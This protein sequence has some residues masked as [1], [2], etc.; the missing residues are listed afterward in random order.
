MGNCTCWVRLA[1]VTLLHR[2]QCRPPTN[3]L[4]RCVE[5]HA[6]SKSFV[7]RTSMCGGKGQ[8]WKSVTRLDI[9]FPG[10][11]SYV[12]SFFLLASVEQSPTPRGAKGPRHQ[13]YTN[14]IRLFQGRLV[15]G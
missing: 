10:G 9:C 12:A 2:Q 15:H 4:E 6:Q 7:S 5:Q 11:R 14:G 3:K 13:R 8:A 1:D